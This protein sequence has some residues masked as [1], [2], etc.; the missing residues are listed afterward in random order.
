[1]HNVR[2]SIIGVVRE[3]VSCFAMARMG[4]RKAVRGMTA[5]PADVAYGGDGSGITWSSEQ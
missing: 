2:R 4:V 5:P 1:M 3:M